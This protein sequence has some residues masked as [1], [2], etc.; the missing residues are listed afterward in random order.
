MNIL[1]LSHFSLKYFFIPFVAFAFLSA[2]NSN[3]NSNWPQFRGPESNQ[4]ALEKELPGEWSMQNNLLWK[5]DLKG[6]GWSCPIVW[7]NQ[8]FFTNA[9]LEEPSIL[10]PAERGRRQDNPDSAV[11]NFE[12][13]C[14]DIDTG[15]EIWKKVAYK[16]L[17]RY[18][19]HRDNNYAPETMVTD[20]KYVYAY[21][22]MTGLYCY[23][24]D[25]NL[26]WEKDL[27]NYPMQSNWGTSSSPILYKGVLYMQIDNEE[28]SFLAAIDSKTGDEIWRIDR[29]EKSNWGTP[30]IWKNSL[31][32]ELV[33]QGAK[34]RS[35][36]PK[37]GE[38]LWELDM[39]GGRNITSPT[40]EGD[41]IFVGN[42]KRSNGGGT[43]F[44]IKAGAS[45]DITLQEGE[46]SNEYVLWSVPESGIAM[47]SPLVYDGLIYIVDRNRGQ[48]Y[49][50]EAATG[51]AVYPAIKIKDASDFWAS[52]WAFDGKIYC[53]DDKGTTHVIQAGREFRELGKNKLDDIFWAST[54]IAKSSYIFRGEKG[55][56]CVR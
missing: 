21:Y 40:A 1:K 2:C 13:I 17:P 46:V 25:G 36:N 6:R 9:V 23:E 56:Y 54:A 11:Y 50:Y 4:I 15:K 19:T 38:M 39:R 55:I 42:E 10:P 14:L 7:G 31:R 5:H 35:Y 33:V 45:G 18:K 29:D 49:C 3:K 27:G 34:T 32:T 48:M 47:A 22:G 16:G 44:G 24:M 43:L 52:P 51:S 41:M 20:G 12:V 53:L 26:V 28:K 30:I 8:V 37:N